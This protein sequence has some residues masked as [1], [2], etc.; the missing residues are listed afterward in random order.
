MDYLKPMDG[1]YTVYTR[2]GCSY[3][4]MVMELLKNEEPQVDEVCCDEYIAHSKPKFFQ[5]I[6]EISG[7]NHNT[8]PI[9]FLDGEF[10][11]GYT[12][13]RA[14]LKYLTTLPK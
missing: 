13:T 1:I 12:E 7:Q 11:G 2:T 5:F 9:V 6:K 10:V 14:F 3:C 8:F 4:K